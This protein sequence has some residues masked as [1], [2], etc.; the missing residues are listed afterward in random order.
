MD[1]NGFAVNRHLELS[2]AVRMVRVEYVAPYLV[3]G[4]RP[5]Y[6]LQQPSEPALAGAVL[7]VDDREVGVS[8]GKVRSGFD[9]VKAMY[10]PDL[11]N[12]DRW[13][14]CGLRQCSSYYAQ[15]AL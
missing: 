5:A 15:K 12:P 6:L 1:I 2:P 10:L 7:T 14:C 11:V 13:P 8:E 3:L 9:G 4:A